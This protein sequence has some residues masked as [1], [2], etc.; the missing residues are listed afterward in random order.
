M[1]EFLTSVAFARCRDPWDGSS[2]E[3]SGQ[4]TLRLVSG[5]EPLLQASVSLDQGNRRIA[6]EV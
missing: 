1:T 2:Y 6:P 3:G 4:Y 5:V